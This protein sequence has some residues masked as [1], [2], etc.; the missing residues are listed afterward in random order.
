MDRISQNPNDSSCSLQSALSVKPF[1]ADSDR[2]VDAALTMHADVAVDELGDT[3]LEDDA[4]VEACLE[5]S[6][7][8]LPKDKANSLHDGLLQ[9]LG[10]RYL[11]LCQASGKCTGRLA[12]EER[13]KRLGIDEKAPHAQR[14]NSLPLAFM[15]DVQEVLGIRR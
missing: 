9:C 14:S 2:F 8:D 1:L 6:G 12:M 4:S 7:A 15:V 5:Q 3:I 11:G 10:R 13:L